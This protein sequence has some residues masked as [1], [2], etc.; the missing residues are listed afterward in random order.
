MPLSSSTHVL[1]IGGDDG[2]LTLL[3][4]ALIMHGESGQGN[5]PGACGCV[6]LSTLRDAACAAG[7]Q[8]STVARACS[9]GCFAPKGSRAQKRPFPPTGAFF[10]T[11]IAMANASPSPGAIGFAAAQLRTCT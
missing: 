8:R 7:G 9:C 6:D 2:V 10:G 3:S 5:G 11:R 1:L 4:I